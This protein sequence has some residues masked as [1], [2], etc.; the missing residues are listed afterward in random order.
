MTTLINIPAGYMRFVPAHKQ[1]DKVT[2]VLSPAKWPVE[3][4]LIA[5]PKGREAFMDNNRIHT[6][7]APAIQATSHL[8]PETIH[9]FPPHSFLPNGT[10]A[11]T[12]EIR[13]RP[14]PASPATPA[15]DA[16]RVPPTPP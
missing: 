4:V 15:M 3:F 5:N 9:F 10:A 14:L 16:P 12:S 13:L 1:A 11:Q 8:T 7:L 6:I 2:V